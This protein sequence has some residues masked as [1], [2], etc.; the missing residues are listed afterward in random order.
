MSDSTIKPPPSLYEQLDALSISPIPSGILSGAL[1]LKALT[2]TT[3]AAAIPNSGTS[4]SSFA[5]HKTLAA[6]RPTRLSCTLFGSAMALGTYM[7]IDGDPLNASGFN[8]A[9]S[10]LYLIVNGKSSISSI[11]KGRVTPVALSG[12]ALFDAALYGREFFWSKRSPFQQ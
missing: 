8:F 1:F 9:W 10:T 4:G 11:F 7:M 6:S 2:K 5:F 3:S 12:L